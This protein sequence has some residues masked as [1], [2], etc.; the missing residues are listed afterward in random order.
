MCIE[1]V[2]KTVSANLLISP[3]MYYYIHI[4]SFLISK[5]LLPHA[6]NSVTPNIHLNKTKTQCKKNMAVPFEI[7]FTIMILELLRLSQLIIHMLSALKSLTHPFE[8][9]INTSI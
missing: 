6:F 9:L 1:S 4:V 8:H 2:V 3:T 5:Y 7:F